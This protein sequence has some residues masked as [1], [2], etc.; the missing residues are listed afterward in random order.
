M[1]FDTE[2]MK[3]LTMFP[4]MSS[5]SFSVF[6]LLIGSM[7][8]MRLSTYWKVWFW[9]ADKVYCGGISVIS[10]SLSTPTSKWQF[11]VVLDV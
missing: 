10:V 6:S 5:I 4:S 1:Q 9:E 8:E 3:K 11:I 2:Q 7:V